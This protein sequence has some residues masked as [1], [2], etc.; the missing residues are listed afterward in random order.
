MTSSKTNVRQNT[1]N[2]ST[3]P[4]P[5]SRRQSKTPVRTPRRRRATI[6][7]ANLLTPRRHRRP[8]ATPQ[9]TLRILSRAL[10]RETY[11]DDVAVHS[12]AHYNVQQEHHT[13]EVQVQ[14]IQGE[15]QPVEQSSQGF[16]EDHD[17]SI[18][19]DFQE[20]LDKQYEN[21]IGEIDGTRH[22]E[23]MHDDIEDR[24]RLSTNRRSERFAQQ[25]LS[26]IALPIGIMPD[27]SIDAGP[28]SDTFQFDPHTESEVLHTFSPVV[29][30][31]DLQV[32]S[33]PKR[34]NRNIKN[35]NTRFQRPAPL[36]NRANNRKLTKFAQTFTR[37][38]LS[39][40][41]MKTL[42]QTS[43]LFFSQVADDLQA[44]TKHSKNKEVINIKS[45]FLL[46]K[47]QRHIGSIDSLLDLVEDLLPLEQVL[48]L[49]RHL[50]KLSR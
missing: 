42:H 11:A 34:S 16:T 5:R 21:Q 2:S 25:A 47:R 40:E 43:E 19:F 27:E 14:N 36:T 1:S 26:D 31:K 35:S 45:V 20:D 22:W 29:N 3:N 38:S 13:T 24:R 32:T 17:L 37:K 10:A 18:D 48:E 8:S 41:A 7:S 33:N 12:D 6:V 50:S 30:T 39:K 9:N 44:Y 4:T 46:L 23:Q 15:N 28:F 49:R